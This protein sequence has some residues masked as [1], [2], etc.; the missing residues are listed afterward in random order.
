[1][2][3]DLGYFKTQCKKYNLRITPQR[4]SIYR[5]VLDSQQHL[6]AS[7]VFRKVKKEFSNI[8][9]NTV[10][11]TLLTFSEINL[12]RVVEGSGTP[13]RFDPNFSAH[14]HI[15]CEKCGKIEDFQNRT[16]DELPIP[17]HLARDYKITIKRVVISGI[18]KDCQKK[19]ILTKKY[20]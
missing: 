4:I 14:H 12:V 20:I 13:R 17:Q 10:H 18:C 8:S 6:T 1:M 5:T 16:Y 7:L 15:H 2:K 11:Q 19:K 9:F 3:K